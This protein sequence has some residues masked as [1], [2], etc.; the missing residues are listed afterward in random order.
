M[1]IL[2]VNACVSRWSLP[3]ITVAP[4]MLLFQK[5]K[6]TWQYFGGKGSKVILRAID[7]KAVNGQ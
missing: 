5:K 1:V 4:D 7:K 6:R 2:C 3:Y